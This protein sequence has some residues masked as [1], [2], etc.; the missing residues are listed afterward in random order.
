MPAR[1]EYVRDRLEN[2]LAVPDPFDCW[3]KHH[4]T[5]EGAH[6]RRQTVLPELLCRW[7]QRRHLEADGAA[8][9]PG[10][11]VEPYET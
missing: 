9:G 4:V 5:Q 6:D 10:E 3:R 7:A 1:S 8:A 11:P 2:L